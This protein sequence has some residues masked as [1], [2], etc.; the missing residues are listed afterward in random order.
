[1]LSVSRPTDDMSLS[2][3]DVVSELVM[4]EM[5]CWHSQTLTFLLLMYV[6]L[7]SFSVLFEV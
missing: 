5:V 1:M 4:L 3:A 2:Y 7:L 6:R